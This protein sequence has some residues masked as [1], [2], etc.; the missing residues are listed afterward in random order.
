MDYIVKELQ[1]QI[2]RCKEDAMK[3]NFYRTL[4]E[5]NLRLLTAILWQIRYDDVPEKIRKEWICSLT[6]GSDGNFVTVLKKIQ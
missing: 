4:I 5:Y 6:K 3:I 2:K 1:K